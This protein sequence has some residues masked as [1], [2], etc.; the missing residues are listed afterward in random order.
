[1][2]CKIWIVDGLEGQLG[3]G[4]DPYPLALP[5]CYLKL[6]RILFHFPIS[7][8]T[9]TG[10]GSQPSSLVIFTCSTCGDFAST[11]KFRPN[12]IV[13]CFQTPAAYFELNLAFSNVFRMT[14]SLQLTI[15]CLST[16]FWVNK[17]KPHVEKKTILVIIGFILIEGKVNIILFE[18]HLP[19]FIKITCNAHPCALYI[20]IYI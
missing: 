12:S 10:H 18:S 3:L 5:F 2:S 9:E 14:K 7:S 6:G 11:R 4:L 17:K 15:S 19:K 1:M 8:K 16:L 20:Y 13:I